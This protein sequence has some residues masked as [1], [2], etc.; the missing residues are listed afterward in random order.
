MKTQS[1]LEI[2]IV[3]RLSDVERL[4]ALIQTATSFGHLHNSD[5]RPYE[6]IDDSV[7]AK[8][9]VDTLSECRENVRGLVASI[10]GTGWHFE[11]DEWSSEAIWSSKSANG[12]LLN[13]FISWIQVQCFQIRSGK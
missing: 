11:N 3:C 7:M 4:N 10:G 2:K 12:E 1:R 5:I 9:E 13:G 6:K 8:I